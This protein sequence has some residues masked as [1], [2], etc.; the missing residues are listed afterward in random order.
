MIPRLT[1]PIR[2]VTGAAV[3]AAVLTVAACS[4]GGAPAAGS[5][6]TAASAGGAPSSGAV[7]PASVL[8]L[9][10]SRASQTTSFRASMDIVS[11]GSY[12]S[13]LAGTLAEQTKPVLLADQKFRVTASGVSVPGSMETMLTSKAIY[14]KISSLSRMAGK[15]WVGIPLSSLKS[16]MGANFGPLI[17]QMQASNPLS[18]T[19]MLPAA[20]N[21][22]QVGSAVVG[23]VQTTEYTGT[24]DP[25]KALR[26]LDPGLRRAAA[27]A[28]AATG[29]R[30]DKF[31]VWVDG[32]HQVR[33]LVQD[34]SGPH[35]Q[36]KSTMVVQAIN[37]PLHITVPPASQIAGMPG[38]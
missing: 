35:Y 37:V 31:S 10:A 22:R 14:L 18:M 12:S 20:A 34:E 1:M 33:K 2:S 4:G 21:V 30:Q 29:I 28:L 17:Q 5:A 19:R 6:T 3:C 7:S 27:P 23:G 9:A 26:R 38:L 16:S 25:A 8:S 15:P 32:Q 11:S 36:V 13:H 24:L